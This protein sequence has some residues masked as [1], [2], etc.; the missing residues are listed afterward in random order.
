MTTTID[1]AAHDAAAPN[2]AAHNAAAQNPGARNTNAHNAD[3][4]DTS[5]PLGQT[6][7]LI[8]VQGAR[9][10]N[11]K[12]VTVE[13]PK[14]QLTVFTGV[15]GSGKSS[16]VFG[17]IAAESQRL[18]N[19]TYS[20]FVQGF[21][22]S[23]GRPDVDVLEGLT[24]AIIV[25]QERMG[26]DTRST[27]G[28]ATD[29]N[30]LLRILF[31]RLGHPHIGSPNAFSFNVASVT[32]SGAITI[33]RGAATKAVK[34]TFTR[35][36]GMC[37]R[38]E[39]RGNVSD[40]DLT[41][42]FDESKSLNEGAITVP[43]FT[44]DGWMVRIIAGSGFFDPDKPIRDY[45]KKQ[46]HDLLYREPTKV[47][48]DNINLTYEGLI[49]R[50]Q[51][52]MLSK[53]R[54]SMQPHI[55]AFVDRAVVFAVCPECEGTRLSESARSSRIDGVNIAQACSMQISDLAEWMHGVNDS[56][57]AP[58]VTA[59]QAILTS[60]VEIGLGYLSLDRPS[61]TLS[62]GEAQRV[63]MVRHL[64]S[65]L[66][67]ITYV[68][69]EPTVGLHPHDIE[70]MNALL[71]RLRDKGNTVLVVEHKP[72]TIVIADHV[73]DIGPGA[74]SAGGTICFEGTVEGLRAS[75]TIT[76]RHFDDRSRV[77]TVVRKPTG[78]LGIRGAVANNLHSV[79]VDVPLGVLCVVTGVAGSGKSSLV[80]QSLPLQ[81][82]AA[83]HTIVS[84]DQSGIRGSR[85]SNPA[86]YTSLLEPIR[87]AFAKAN[88]VKPALFSS[89]SEGA[90]PVCNGAGVIYTD[91]AIMAG[92][93]TTCEECE[94]KRFDASVLD[95]HFGGRDISE[96]L[97]MSVTDALQFFAAGEARL[98]AA[99]AILSR[100]ADVGLGYLTIGQPL[101]TLS[102]GE[103]QRL[104]LAVNLADKGGVYVLDEP[105]TGLHLADVE[106]LLGLLDRIVDSGKSVIVVE[107]HQAVMAHADWIID[108]GPGA[109][110][111][112]GQVVFE[113]TPADLVAAR[114]TLTGEHLAAYVG[115]AAD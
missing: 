40:F 74:G 100:L 51:R 62:G 84:I 57:V 96:V 86:T 111:D 52:S 49:V 98:P 17:T 99:H 115:Q 69:D 53:D 114:S 37:P 73:V 113:G 18:I 71:L 32:G 39:G 105:T 10:N 19:E 106:Q 95:Y 31:S 9:V 102:G 93:A 24:T 34:Q 70:R 67:D 83:N 50:V 66:T 6:H 77:K 36:G 63:K 60:F 91:L 30:A 45:T 85:R 16:L 104:K 3:G 21:M 68:F 90:C 61:G 89:N 2:D 64:G 38:C 54:D 56:S 75:D 14:R 101:T 76:G 103:R 109:G 46:M 22:P 12:D 27:V 8:R 82:D 112:G 33:E 55:R 72:E 108:L 80:H 81:P 48:V 25:D 13:I 5:A 44:G 88:G 78:T 20:A 26:A 94:G 97:A 58:L 92:V 42:L 43:G 1:A 87:K 65:A 23:L 4:P 107:H 15:S 59:L 35:T 7:D 79:D 41:Q 110:H 47:K 28:T 29:A 11:L